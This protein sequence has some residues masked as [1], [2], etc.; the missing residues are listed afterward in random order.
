M[1][2]G[3]GMFSAAARLDFPSLITRDILAVLLVCAFFTLGCAPPEENLAAP[4]DRKFPVSLGDRTVHVELAVTQ[5]ET[6]RGLMFRESLEEDSGMLFVFRHPRRM[7]FYMLNTPIPLDIG[8]FSDAG[9]LREVYALHPF[10]ENIVPSQSARIQFALEMEQGWFSANG[11]RRG[12]Q[13]DLEEVAAA[14]R[15]RGFAPEGFG[16]GK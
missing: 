2:S 10:D 5:E 4:A 15:A 1:F 3:T 7:S 9:I 13:L 8:Y 16:L 14:L 6:S 11:I 12:A